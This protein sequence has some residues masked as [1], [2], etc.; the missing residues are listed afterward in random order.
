V[1]NVPSNEKRI[2]AGDA[3]R[4]GPAFP[5]RQIRGHRGGCIVEP[6]ENLDA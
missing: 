2:V 6:K 1:L 4:N 5:Q 3:G